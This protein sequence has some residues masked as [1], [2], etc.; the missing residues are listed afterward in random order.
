MG[1][2]VFGLLSICVIQYCIMNGLEKM[3]VHHFVQDGK[4]MRPQSTCTEEVTPTNCLGMPSGHAEIGT[5]V[6][7]FLYSRNYVSLPTAALLAALVCL[8]RIFSN[9]HTAVQTAAGV[10]LGF[11]YFLLY[12]KQSWFVLV[13]LF[14]YLNVLLFLVERSFTIPAWIQKETMELV[15]KKRNLSYPIKLINLL[16]PAFQQTRPLVITWAEVEAG[17]DKII[18]SLDEPPDAIVG[19]K[20]GGAILADYLQS[21]LNVPVFKVKVSN[22]RYKC[23]KK[24]T[25]DDYWQIMVLKNKP[26][27]MMCEGVEKVEGTVLLIDE[28]VASGGQMELVTNYLYQKGAKKVYRAAIT[29]PPNIKHIYSAMKRELTPAVWPWGYDN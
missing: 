15:E 3:I 2:S 5:M 21:K 1:F 25:I 12:S 18:A 22:R 14:F 17:L 26:E 27:Y 8:E 4:A 7:L 9:H 10:L 11:V 6:A 20:T 24:N 29:S 16:A 28:C 13:V 19:I 23:K